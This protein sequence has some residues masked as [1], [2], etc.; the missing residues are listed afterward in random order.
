MTEIVLF[1]HGQCVYNAEG[2]VNGICDTELSTLGEQQAYVLAHRL[3]EPAVQNLVPFPTGDT[4]FTSPLKRARRTGEIVTGH[5]RLF[6]PRALGELAERNLG[7]VTGMT[8]EAA[9]QLIAEEDKIHTAYGVTYVESKRY[10]FET[11]AEATE[12]G[13]TCLDFMTHCGEKAVVWAFTHGDRALSLIAA[14][15]GKPMRELIH[16]VHIPNTGVVV[17]SGNHDYELVDVVS[18]DDAT[19]SA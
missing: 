11:F 18:R 17:L 4:V 12:K 8:F 15:A 13:Q 10:G 2:R 6:A 14:W 16:E 7:D 9:G 1:R 19:M 5:L 3:A